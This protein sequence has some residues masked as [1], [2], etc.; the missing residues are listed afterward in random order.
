VTTLTIFDANR[1]GLGRHGDKWRASLLQSNARPFPLRDHPQRSIESTWPHRVSLRGSSG[2]Q[3]S[4]RT[5]KASPAVI[6]R[7]RFEDDSVDLEDL[8]LTEDPV[9]ESTFEEIVGSSDALNCVLG[10]V[11]KVAP[12][13]ATV[14]ITGE[15]GTGKDLVARAIHKRSYRSGRPFVRVNCAA[16]PPSLIASELFGYEKGAFTGAAQRHSGRFEVANGGTIFLDEIGDIPTEAQVALLRVLQE[17]EFERVGGTHPIPVDVRVI[18]ATHRDLRAAVASGAFRQDLL[19]R[20]NVFPLQMPSLRE[21]RA[22]IPL[23]VSHF[24]G[25]HAATSGKRI[26]SIERRTLSWLQDYDW[27]GNI[28][29]LQNVIERAVILCEGET[30]SIDESW[31]EVGPASTSSAPF[32]LSSILMNEEREFIVAALRDSRGRISG[33]AGAAA[34]LRMPRTTL[35]FKI[36]RLQINKHQFRGA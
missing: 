4:V 20:L 25:R 18:A 30:L 10:K 16:L 9:S 15:S 3:Q 8:A 26:R 6:S 31:L 33:P 24:I 2:F 27:P 28:R 21:R 35:E 34:K 29:E 36:K 17:R 14:L 7:N 23:L 5:I 19:Y 32:E 13:N 22:D 1:D 12:T 11:E